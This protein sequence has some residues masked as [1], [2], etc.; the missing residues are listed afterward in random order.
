MLIPKPA[1]E[2]ALEK[3]TEF[4]PIIGPAVKYTK[5][6][7][8][9]TKFSDPVKATTRSV[10]YL[11]SACSGPV[12]KYPALCSL[13]LGTGAL[14]FAAENPTLIGASLEFAQL[15]LEEI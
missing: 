13:W 14:G 15:I 3:T 2:K 6:A 8:A 9:V 4:A 1:I 12:I 7:I 11:V 10:G 5:K